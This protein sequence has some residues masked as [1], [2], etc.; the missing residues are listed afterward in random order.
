MTDFWKNTDINDFEGEEWKNIQ[1]Y[2][3]RRPHQH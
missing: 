3:L 2:A 1:C